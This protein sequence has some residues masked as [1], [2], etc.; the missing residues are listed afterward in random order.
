MKEEHIEEF[1]NTIEAYN[2][3]TL[4][5]NS[6]SHVRLVIGKILSNS[7]KIKLEQ[8]EARELQMLKRPNRLHIQTIHNAK[9]LQYRAVF[10]CSL[11]FAFTQPKYCK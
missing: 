8:M 6:K 11:N 1:L 9:G 2:D 7:D 5:E 3:E 10:L 4:R